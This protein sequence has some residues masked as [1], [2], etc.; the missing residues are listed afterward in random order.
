MNQPPEQPHW[1]IPMKLP[2]SE[3][4]NN[5]EIDLS[6]YEEI[7]DIVYA[8]FIFIFIIGLLALS[9]KIFSAVKD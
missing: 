1:L 4:V 7:R 6:W 3:S 9:V 5:I 8:V 2:G